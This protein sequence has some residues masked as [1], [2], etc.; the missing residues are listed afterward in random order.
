MVN[1]TIKRI[2]SIDMLRGIIMIIM[3]LDHTRDFFS[4]FYN[5][6]T[7][8][9][10][11]ST[12]MF[13]TRWITH[14]CAPIFVF[15]SGVSAYLSLN[16]GKTTKEASWFLFTRGIWL[17]ILEL[18][19][20]RLGWQFNFDYSTIF[21]QVIWA[22]GWS[23]IFL[24]LLVFLPMPLILSIGAVMVLLHNTLDTVHAADFGSNA[25]WWN[26]F[27]EFGNAP[28]GAGRF[29]VIYPLVPWIG[30]MALGYCFGTLFRKPE[31]ERNRWFHI[32]GSS[33]IVLFIVLRYTNAYGDM[34]PWTVQPAWWRT[35][36][37]FIN[38]TKYPPSL[39]YLLM[40]IGPAILSLPL[41][42]R[43]S[44]VLARIF[45]VYGRVPMFYYLLHIYLIHGMAIGVAMIMD[46][47]LYYFTDTSMMF[48]PKPGWGFS[49]PMVY[50]FWLTAVGILY[51]PCKW[52]MNIKL[53]HK[54]WWLSYL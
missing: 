16:K 5:D 19:V 15:L 4:N 37:S 35:V 17:I 38:C 14:Y 50:V 28:L 47:P 42:E 10:V 6:P 20:V 1:N 3:A 49:L 43:L 11:S 46:L 29:M 13:F 2:N 48:A 39:L 52:F 32:I 36:L 51:L 21:V 23:M 8:L 27:H 7:D 9:S 33:A 45:T 31:A 54:K 40:T 44:G 34:R 12:P 22:L 18:T 24:S 26:I 30:V 25:I 53:N 41:L